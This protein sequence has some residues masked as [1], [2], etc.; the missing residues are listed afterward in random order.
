MPE[1]TL[2]VEPGT[3]ARVV[4]SRAAKIIGVNELDIAT[5][6]RARL[7]K[8]LGN[9]MPCAPKYFA[10]CELV[11]LANDPQWLDKAT[12]AITQYWKNKNSRR[13]DR[14]LSAAA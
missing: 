10:T 4:S 5:L 1:F 12:R 11:Q 7:L 6:V 8:P 9:P 13:S 2:T 3:P 14:R